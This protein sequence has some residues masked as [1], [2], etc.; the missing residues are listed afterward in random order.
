MANAMLFTLRGVPIVYYGDEQGFS[1]LGGDQ[2]ARED[3]FMSRVPSY[4][5]EHS[6][7]STP[8]S[9]RIPFD[10]SNVLFAHIARLAK[11]RLA[12]D[13]LRHGRQV[14]RNYSS[15]PGLF[16]VS[17]F[18]PTTGREYVIAF[19]TSSH[20]VSGAIEVEAT[21]ARFETLAGSCPASA[22]A[23]ASMHVE[24]DA[25]GYAVCAVSALH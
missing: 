17:R 11:L 19:N 25:F 14:V 4:L 22:S 9:E 13:A 23:P 5:A 20:P 18:D 10:R 8:S 7:G 21:S 24:L 1:G 6:L 15:T 3:M 12:H 2:D 16:A